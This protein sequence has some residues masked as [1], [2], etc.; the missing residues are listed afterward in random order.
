MMGRGCRV[1]GAEVVA[2]AVNVPDDDELF[3]P[4][5]PAKKPEPPPRAIPPLPD[6]ALEHYDNPQPPLIEWPPR[7][8]VAW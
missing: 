6:G 7:E 1:G 4:M 5:T 8:R 2:M 3:E